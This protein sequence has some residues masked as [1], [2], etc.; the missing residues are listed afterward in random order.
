VASDPQVKHNQSL[1]NLKG[2]KGET[3]TLVSHPIRYDGEVPKI[4][5]PPQEVGAQ[6]RDLLFELGYSMSQIQTLE[7]DGVVKSNN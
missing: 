4:R 7:S 6:T 1:I 2:A 5:I 3:I